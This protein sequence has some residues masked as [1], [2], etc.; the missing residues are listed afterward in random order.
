MKLRAY[1]EK[2]TPGRTPEPGP[3]PRRGPAAPHLVFVVHKHAA[4][5]LHYDLRLELG[6][7][8]KSFAVPKGPSLDPSVRRLA[9][10][11]EDHPYDYKDFEGVIPEGNYGAGEVIVWDRGFYSAPAA[12]DKKDSEKA[13]LAGLEKGD[14]K[15]VLA[16]SKLKGEFALVKTRQDEKSWLLLKKKDGFATSADV[17]GK[18]RSVVSGRTVEELS[19]GGGPARPEAGG[20]AVDEALQK[21]PLRPMPRGVEPMLAGAAKKPFDHPGWV[22]EVKWDGYRAVAELGKKGVRLYSRNKKSLAERFPAVAAALKELAAEAVLDGEIVAADKDGRPSFQLLQDHSAGR[23]Y[24]VYYVFDILFYRGRDL[25]GLPLTE[26][27]ALLKGLLPA[28]GHVRYSE[29]VPKDGVNFFRAAKARGLEGIVAKRAGSPY[30]AGARSPD[31]LKIKN[32]VT[33]DCVIAG[34]TRPRGAGRWFGSLV[35]GAYRNGELVYIGHSGGGTGGA[36]PGRLHARLLALARKSCPFAARPPLETGV[37][38]VK[39]ELVCE[40]EYT[41]WTADGLLRQPAMLRLREDKAARE[42]AL[43][44][45]AA[46]ATEN[47]RTEP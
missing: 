31:W 2:R 25:T 43:E 19:V 1:K 30:R 4:R 29:H 24:L 13:L 26:R 28:A 34:F 37:T 9:V 18:D 33:Q 38:W 14:L 15:F 44:T 47:G 41:E 16:G 17:L 35:L 3:A 22:F 7:V 5:R 40:V 10:Q 45:A 20:G 42:A 27:K 23:G 11:V 46:A 21:A 32:R 6:G 12:K 8:L 39:P 36:D